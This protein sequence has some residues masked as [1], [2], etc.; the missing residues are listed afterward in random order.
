MEQEALPVLP[1]RAIPRL[2]AVLPAGWQAL[3]MSPDGRCH[4]LVH[5]GQGAILLD[6][7]PEGTPGIEARMGQAMAAAG[8]RGSAVRVPVWYVRLDPAQLARFAGLLTTALAGQAMQASMPPGWIDALRGSLRRHSAWSLQGAASV[9]RRG[10]AWRG[11]TIGT[12]CAVLGLAGVVLLQ[13]GRTTSSTAAAT[14][15]QEPVLA[16]PPTPAMAMRADDT[17]TGGEVP[18][19]PAAEPIVQPSPLQAMAM[20]PIEDRPAP[21]AD[22][23]PPVPPLA[24]ASPPVRPAPRPPSRVVD[25]RCVDAQFRWAQGQRLS[26]GEMAY[27]RNGCTPVRR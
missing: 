22:T 15:V 3:A 11:I 19:D 10:A 24:A 6:L 26:W 5:P 23:M 20:Q 27:V 21:Q 1:E 2:A 17:Q 18:R 25:P 14:A 4:V 7:A 16:A 9:P 12:T 8:L 13:E